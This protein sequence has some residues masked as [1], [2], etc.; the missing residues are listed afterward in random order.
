MV[1]NVFQQW[2][3]ILSEHLRSY[4]S[5][6]L[7]NLDGMTDFATKECSKKKKFY[8]DHEEADT[9]MFAYIKFLSNTVQLKVVI[10]DSPDTDVAVISL[11]HYVTNLVLLDSIW[12]KTGTGNKKRIYTNTLT[13]IRV[14]FINL[15]FASC[16]K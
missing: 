9:K 3:E 5:V 8:C 14:W 4:Q 16:H 1:S 7:V 6:Y 2:K 13:D 12:F 10:I 15:L 11:Y